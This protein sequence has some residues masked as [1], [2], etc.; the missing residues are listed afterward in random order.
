L[1]VL[2]CSEVIRTPSVRIYGVPSNAH[3]IRLLHITMGGCWL[4]GV[5]PVIYGPKVYAQVFL[6]SPDAQTLLQC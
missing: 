1:C 2:N 4:I 5:W 3:S 6:K